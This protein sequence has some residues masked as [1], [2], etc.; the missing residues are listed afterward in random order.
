M[1]AIA[2]IILN[3]FDTEAT[4]KCI[5]SVRNRLQATV[6]LIDNS[7]DAAEKT[8]LTALFQKCSDIHCSFRQKISDLQAASILAFQK[9]S[10]EGII[11]FY[12]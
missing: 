10:V 5:D 3:Y 4:T 8:K 12:Y 9:Q 6:F 7:A 11:V 1:N 2:V